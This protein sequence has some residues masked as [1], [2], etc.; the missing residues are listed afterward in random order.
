MSEF[1]TKVPRRVAPVQDTMGNLVFRKEAECNDLVVSITFWVKEH[2]ETRILAVIPVVR[3]GNV[4]EYH[5]V[6]AS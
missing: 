6:K 3:D 2:P 4:V 1:V 5:L